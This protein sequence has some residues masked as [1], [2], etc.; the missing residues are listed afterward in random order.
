MAK[1]ILTTDR[2]MRPIAEFS[3]AHRVGDVIYVGATAGTDARRE[4]AGFAPG[5]IDVAAQTAKMLENME[6]AL[7][8]LGGRLEDVVRMKGYLNDWR[9]FPVYEK[10]VAGFFRAPYPSQLTVGSWGFPL[11]QA[12]A[13]AE[14]VAVVGGANA[15]VRIARDTPFVSAYDRGGVRAGGQF[16]CVALPVGP[17]GDLVGGR[18]AAA[19]TE[20]MLD[21]LR[22]A[23]AAADLMPRDAVMLTVTLADLRDYPAFEQLF[24]QFFAAPFPARTIV[25]A[26]LCLPDMAASIECV[27]LPGGGTPIAGPGPLEQLGAASPAMLAGDV[28]YI[29]GQLGVGRDGGMPGS[30]EA[31]TVAAWQRIEALVRAAGMSLDDVVSTT[32]VL[33]DW[34]DY[35]AFNAGFA[36]FVAAPFPPRTTIS[37]GLLDRRAR[38]Q[39]EAT[40][41]RQGRDA[42]VLEVERGLAAGTSLP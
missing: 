32:N 10:T 2:L 35:R 30:V 42:C 4:L 17:S 6:T 28:L 33:S 36:R 14:L 27:A 23:L 12:V 19:Q 1:T 39:I 7:T 26:P 11:P 16:Y 37:V 29:G 15:P 18:D 5:R 31:Q 20:L 40:A 22:A 21:N 13:E 41:H 8:L 34:R 38:V 24:R 9:D 25:V 3:M